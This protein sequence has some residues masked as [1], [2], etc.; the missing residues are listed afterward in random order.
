M[1]LCLND[2]LRFKTTPAGAAH[3]RDH[4]KAT[5]ESIL[6]M[7]KPEAR[8]AFAA[9]HP[10]ASF[11]P[12]RAADGLWRMAFKEFLEAFAAAPEILREDLIDGPVTLRPAS[13]ASFGLERPTGEVVFDMTFDRL[14]VETTE[15][16]KRHC[17]I[18]DQRSPG[19]MERSAYRDDGRL[20]ISG[21]DLVEVFGDVWD[22]ADL[23]SETLEVK[24]RQ[25]RRDVAGWRAAAW[26]G[27]EET[28]NGTPKP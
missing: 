27:E 3:L 8:D 24:P 9:A 26:S 11:L 22:R 18:R 19:I 2:T 12:T 13:F 28:P 4:G 17:Q 23:F 1:K 20:E 21:W 15:D 16:G 25:P 14:I 6:A 10:P 7:M 5:R